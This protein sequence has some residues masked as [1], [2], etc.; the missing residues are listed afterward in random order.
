MNATQQALLRA[1]HWQIGNLQVKLMEL[2]TLLGMIQLLSRL[3]IGAADWFNRVKM[4]L[5]VVTGHMCAALI[6]FFRFDSIIADVDDEEERENR[7]RRRV[8]NPTLSFNDLTDE[9]LRRMTRFSRQSLVILKK[10]FIT[11]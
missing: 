1:V 7:Q 6:V 8:A 4:S 9:E 5:L 10:K 11:K 3:Y 2:L